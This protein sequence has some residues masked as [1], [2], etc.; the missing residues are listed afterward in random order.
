MSIK[1]T[2]DNVKQ[3]MRE[4][5]DLAANRVLVGIPADKTERENGDPINNAMLGYIH[6]NGAPEANIPARP[7]LHPGINKVR[8]KIAARAKLAAQAALKGDEGSS[9]RHLNAMGLIGQNAARNEIQNGD[10][11]PLSE[12][13]LYRRKHRKVAPRMGERPLIDTGQMRNSVT[14]VI[15]KK[16]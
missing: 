13:T 7:W 14:Y 9:M 12:K 5:Q 6:E 11:L 2:K 3:V 15:R 8:D 4:I 1:V 16:G 10:H